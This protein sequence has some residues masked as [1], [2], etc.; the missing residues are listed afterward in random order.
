[1]TRRVLVVANDHVGRSMGGPGIRSLRFAQQLA[2]DADV[3]L[4]VPFATDVVSD[5]VEI[6]QDDPWDD[7]RM[8]A[9]VQ[10]F[11]AVVAQSLPVATM[12]RLARSDTLAVYDLYAPWSLEALAQWGHAPP[13]KALD[14]ESR[15]TL[16]K[17]RAALACGDAF[18]C[19][20]ER[21]RDLWLGALL[22]AGRIDRRAYADD[23][24]LRS[25]VDVVPFGIDPEPPARTGPG[26][27]DVV[28]RIEPGDRIVLW[29]GGIWSW[30]DP[31]TVIHA[32]HRLA[33]RRPEVKLVFL[34]LSHPNPAV[35]QMEMQR[36]ALALADELGAR[37][38]SVLFNHGWVPYEER[39]SWFLDA[40]VGVSA[41]LD[42]IEARFAFRTRLLDCFWAGL[43]VVCTGGDTLAD[44]VQ[45]RG[46]GR[47]VP[48]GD[49]DGWERA[50]EGVL[51][52][53]EERARI[54]ERLAAVREELAWARVVEPLRRLVAGGSPTTASLPLLAG[55]EY[56]AARV[57]NAL[58]ARGA[59]GTATRL[60]ERLTGRSRPIEERVKPPLR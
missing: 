56:A 36:R 44:L 41:H 29:G 50:L 59:R 60:L 52:D 7:R 49:V 42:G 10:G 24:A 47:T 27:R 40:D 11:D 16:L 20:S 17:L 4:V 55:A 30:F 38:R 2:R 43:P 9:R 5:A 46:L 1:V 54:G 21:Q 37:D 18:V 12:R 33:Q 45:L 13:S 3:T 57:E 31:L 35:P 32:V 25:L 51:D 22:A 34:A 58:R 23:A 26:L 19:A 8:R 28:P 15:V 6:V 48:P 39:G 14:A 53:G